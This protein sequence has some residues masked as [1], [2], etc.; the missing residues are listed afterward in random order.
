MKRMDF[1]L[2]RMTE[3]EAIVRGMSCYHE[4]NEIT[5]ACP[6]CSCKWYGNENLCGEGHRVCLECY[7]DYYTNVSYTT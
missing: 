5:N 7:Q 3:D 1:N 4:S 6:E 2:K